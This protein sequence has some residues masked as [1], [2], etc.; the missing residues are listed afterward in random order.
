L[1]LPIRTGCFHA[2]LAVVLLC[3]FAANFST[4][5]QLADSIPAQPGFLKSEFIFERAPFRSCHASTI[6]ETRDGL[7]AAWFGGTDEGERDV[8]IWLSR[9]DGNTWAEPVEVANGADDEKHI[10]YACWN[11]VLFQPK[12]GPLLLFYKVGPTPSSWWGMLIRSEDGGRSWSK[13][14]RLPKDIYGPIKNKPVELAGNWIICG[15]SS[16]DAGWRVHMERTRSFGQQWSRTGPLNAAMEFG[17]IQPAVLAYPSGKL[18]ILNRTKLRQISECWSDDDG[19]TWSRMKATDLPNPNSGIDAVVLRDGRALLVYNHTVSGRGVLN[20][21][22][23]PD[24]KRW[25]A[26]VVV[27][28]EPGSEFSYPAV[29]QSSDGLVHAT[30]TWKRERIKHVAIDPFKLNLREMVEGQWR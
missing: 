1:T 21:A 19:Q 9:H 20:V 6:V 8:G 7:M 29:I 14:R 26:A 28:A 17:A 16:E 13:P 15:S 23:S 3:F 4:L 25:H 12:N 10:Q 18:Q 27:E 22:V 2:A 5:A 11:P 30:Y 24:G